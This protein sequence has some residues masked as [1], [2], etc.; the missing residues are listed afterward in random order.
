MGQKPLQSRRGNYN[1]RD[2][3]SPF[4]AEGTKAQ[5]TPPPRPGTQTMAGTHGDILIHQE[6]GEYGQQNGPL[7]K[8]GQTGSGGCLSYFFNVKRILEIIQEDT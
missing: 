2:P 3:Q 5:Q 4:Q 1:S 7:P 6:K 8:D